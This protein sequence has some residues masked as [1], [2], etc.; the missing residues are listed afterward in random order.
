MHRK[1]LLLWSSLALTAIA[2]AQQDYVADTALRDAGLA[3]FWQLA[4]P[5]EP[6][7]QISNAYL[8]DDQ[9]YLCTRGGYVY[10]VHAD[11][12][13]VRWLRQ[14]GSQGQDIARPC[15][16]GERTVF[17]TPTKL[18]VVDR[19]TGQG[20]AERALRFPPGSGLVSNGQF[21]YLGSINQ[22][23]YAFDGLTNY[24]AWKV[25]TNGPITATPALFGE[26][27][28][29]A[30][31]DGAVYACTANKKRFHW[32]RS[33]LA[34]ITADLVADDK[35]VYVASRDS[36]LYLLDLQFGNVRW[37]ARLSGPLYDAPVVTADTAYQFCADDGLVAV[38]TEPLPDENDRLRW[39]LP[40]GRVLLTA[41]E[42]HAFVLSQDQ[43]I[44]MVDAKTGLE[45]QTI[46]APGLTLAMPAPRDGTI[47]LAGTDGRLFCARPRGKPLPRREDLLRALTPP[48]V[49]KESAAATSRPVVELPPPLQQDYLKTEALGSTLGGKSKVSR[50]FSGKTAPPPADSGR[51]RPADSKPAEPKKEPSK[52]EPEPKK[53]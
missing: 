45:L 22:R 24:E 2:A 16:V 41:D 19:L 29:V 5:L 6:G 28:F 34:P 1:P 4:L 40:R 37:R 9:M 11:T 47:F 51:P 26:F 31:E 32:Q 50:D 44:L 23:F 21:Y 35:G 10:A 25:T 20:L 18:L 39:K 17:V 36:S 3:K 14:V 52:K 33:T 27:L 15:H 13:A 53:P 8:V 49:A 48:N 42:K 38:N 43:T 7:E 46:D 12:G 30:S